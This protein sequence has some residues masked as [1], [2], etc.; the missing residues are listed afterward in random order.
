MKK[1]LT[2]LLLTGCGTLPLLEEVPLNTQIDP[3]LK[4]YVDDFLL[5]CK[6]QGTES[7]CLKNLKR[8]KS[9]KLQE[10][11]EPEGKPAGSC[12][13]TSYFG[14]SH[15]GI[16]TIRK[17]Y[18]EALVNLEIARKSLMFHELGHCLGNMDHIDTRPHIMNAK[19]WF[20]YNDTDWQVAVDDMFNSMRSVEAKTIFSLS[21]NGSCEVKSGQ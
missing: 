18:F 8:I 16:I 13:I 6:F 5:S 2:A 1:L 4:P 11:K 10:E 19:H 15:D 12:L 9:I 7:K 3:E 21:I 17:D 14:G 20:P